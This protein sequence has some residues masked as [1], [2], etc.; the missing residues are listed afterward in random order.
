M[1]KRRQITVT[2]GGP[3]PI[4]I[5][6][7]AGTDRTDEEQIGA[8]LRERVAAL[9]TASGAVAGAELAKPTASAIEDRTN[10]G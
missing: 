8:A 10:A 2:F 3:E 1:P 9:G 7:A 5:L 6:R 4:E